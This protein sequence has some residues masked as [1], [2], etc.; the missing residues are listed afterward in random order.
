MAIFRF[1]S[2]EERKFYFV[3]NNKG[4]FYN[5]MIRIDVFKF[6][7]LFQDTDINVTLY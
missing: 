5:Y 1:N 7:D 4:I 2:A 3:N 6:Y